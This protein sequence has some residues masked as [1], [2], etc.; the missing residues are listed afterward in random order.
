[1]FAPEV[2][3][4]I[5]RQVRRVVLVANNPD[6]PAEMLRDLGNG[7]DDLLV[8]FNNARHEEV[9]LDQPCRHMRFHRIHRRLD[10]WAFHYAFPPSTATVRAAL[11]APE[12]H[13]FVLSGEPPLLAHCGVAVADLFFPARLAPCL[14]LF[15]ERT[16]YGDLPQYPRPEGVPFADPSTGFWVVAAL[17]DLRRRLRA[18][19]L[20]T[21][22]LVLAGFRPA[23]SGHFWE[24]HAWDY[25]RDWLARRAASGEIEMAE[26]ECSPAAAAA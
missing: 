21:F 17:L 13:M 6:L 7:A 8:Q 5:A 26:P 11:A 10:G 18:H 1:V 2:E 25:E 16:D 9:L 24:G 22:E 4:A 12:R 15:A 14:S 19:G 20:P 3:F 23:V